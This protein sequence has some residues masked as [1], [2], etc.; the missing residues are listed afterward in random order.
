MR[1]TVVQ[2]LSSDFQ[3]FTAKITWRNVRNSLDP[4]YMLPSNLA[5]Y[6]QAR[7]PFRRPP[8]NL[9]PSGRLSKMQTLVPMGFLTFA[10]A[11]GLYSIA[12]PK[13]LG[14]GQSACLMGI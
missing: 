8:C 1:S 6:A 7:D 4:L 9:I 10:E 5:L 12:L 13:Y 11:L 2:W 14:P 3:L